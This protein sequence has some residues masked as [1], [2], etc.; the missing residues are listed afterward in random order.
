MVKAGF[1]WRRETRE[2]KDIYERESFKILVLIPLVTVDILCCYF[3]LLPNI[4]L[5]AR[6]SRGYHPLAACRIENRSARFLEHVTVT[7]RSTE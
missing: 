4:P 2:G 6:N 7:P 1:L 5:Y 3:I